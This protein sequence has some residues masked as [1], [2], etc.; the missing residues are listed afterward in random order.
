[1]L[2]ETALSY[3]QDYERI[4]NGKYKLP[5]DM[6]SQTEQ[7]SPI[8]ALEQT[9]KFVREAVGTL[10]RRNRGS[11]EDKKVWFDN[12]ATPDL[13]PK[14]YRTAYH[15]QTDGWMSSDSASVYDT[16]TETLFLGKQD[17]MQRMTL[18]PLVEYAKELGRPLKVLEVACGTGRFMTF[19]RDNLSLDSE[20][21]AIDLSPFYLD[22][23]RDYDAKWRSL[24]K[25]ME[26]E[27]N[28]VEIDTIKPA[29]IVQA[30]AENL[31]F[32][33][34]EFDVV[35]CVYLFHELPREIRAKAASEM[36]RVT[37]TGGRVV[38]TDSYQ[39]GDRPIFD[40]QIG[41]FGNMNEPHYRDYIEDLLPKH[42]EDEGLE[43]LAKMVC[44][45]SKSLSFKK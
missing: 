1:M 9:G 44:S 36:A 18:V 12:D 21:T 29:T 35:V 20:Y 14:Y 3:E 38:L 19:A 10:T 28:G 42:F 6:Y 43:C 31:P 33:D 8:F 4:E 41:N 25:R 13:Y 2:I 30:Q 15:Y 7:S 16:S 34:E 39:L 11:D 40:A 17:A 32:A 24:K 22:K 5:Y 27:E 45:S 37:K 26:K 23:A